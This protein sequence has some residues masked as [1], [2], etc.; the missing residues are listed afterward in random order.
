[1]F[2]ARSHIDL[3]NIRM[4]VERIGK[5]SDN[6]IGIGPVGIGLDGI[7]TW[8]PGVGELYS[9]GAGGMLM[10]EGVRARVAPSVMM[11][12]FTIVAVRTVVGEVPIAGKLAVDLFR[13]HK[14]A[15]DMIAKAMDDTLYIEGSRR[16]LK[17][18]PD[19]HE[20]MAR[21]RAGKERRRIVFL[22]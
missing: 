18:H 6:I 19:Y 4:A 2:F 20:T 21:V 3:H 13:G 11:Q 22:G 17:D 7:L 9:L 10:L 5:L 15:A 8:I 14:W 1:M 12:V 16:D